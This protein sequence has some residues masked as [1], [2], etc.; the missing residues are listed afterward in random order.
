MRKPTEDTRGLIVSM[1]NGRSHPQLRGEQCGHAITDPQ[2]AGVA[3]APPE[4]MADEVVWPAVI[5]CKTNHCLT[6]TE[7]HDWLWMELNEF[8]LH[9]L[10]GLGVT[11]TTRLVKFW[12][13]ARET[14]GEDA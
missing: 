14:I 2:M 1:G 3:Y 9:L 13:D 4:A 8:F 12:T 11:D 7:Y 6:S 5:L 10:A